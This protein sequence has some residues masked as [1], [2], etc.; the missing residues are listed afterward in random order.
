MCYYNHH[1]D[2]SLDN[3]IRFGLPYG[4]SQVQILRFQRGF[5]LD[6]II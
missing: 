6:G 3:E 5:G 4:G 2:D 1:I